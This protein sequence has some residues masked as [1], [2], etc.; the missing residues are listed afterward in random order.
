MDLFVNFGDSCNTLPIKYNRVQKR[1]VISVQE[2]NSNFEIIINDVPSE[3]VKEWTNVVFHNMYIKKLG[4]SMISFS[5][6][7][8]QLNRF[9]RPNNTNLLALILPTSEFFEQLSA[10]ENVSVNPIYKLNHRLS[11]EKSLHVYLLDLTPKSSGVSLGLSSQQTK[12]D[13]FSL[14]KLNKLYT[15]RRKIIVPAPYYMW[16]FEE[17]KYIPK[18]TKFLII[19]S[20]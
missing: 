7:P 4:D 10:R 1:I 8:D 16:E 14:N 11:D 20:E 6:I 19:P 15:I 3:L 18:T 5:K 9:L 13:Y 2:N 17:D 12:K